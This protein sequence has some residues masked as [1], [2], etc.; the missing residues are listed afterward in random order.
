MHFR[1]GLLNYVLEFAKRNNYEVQLSDDLTVQS[2]INNDDLHGW[3]QDLNPQSR[4]E[5]IQVRDYQFDA[6]Y[7]ALS[8]ERVLL[9]SP[10]ASGKSLII[11]S[12]LRWHLEHKRKCIVIVPTTSLVEQLYADFEDY[13]SANGWSTSKHCQKLYSGFS[14]EFTKD[15][16]I[17]TW[18]SVYLQPRAWFKQFNVIIGEDRK[19]TRLNSSHT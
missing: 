12:I 13:S 1:S 9:L 8:D 6:I 7:K 2:D 11:Y 15:I 18:Q 19:S 14:K 5:A 10:T 17:T 16:L 3:L 4:N